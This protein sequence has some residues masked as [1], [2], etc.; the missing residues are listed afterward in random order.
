MK[1]IYKITN[2]EDIYKIGI[3]KITSKINNKVYIGSA[4]A[5]HKLKSR[6]GFYR[7]WEEHYRRLRDN[8]HRNRHLQYSWNKYGKDNFIFEILEICNKNDIITKEIYYIDKYDCTNH[9]FGYNMIKNSLVNYNKPNNETKALL[10]KLFKNIPRSADVVKK[11]SN[12]VQQLDSNRK[13]IR[14]YSSMSEASR[15]TGIMRQDIGQ[16]CIGKKIK[17]AGGYFWKKVKDIV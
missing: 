5:Q 10:S 7:R 13:L 2:I 17:K 6:C 14:E 12:P 1:D 9:K 11:Y 4:S 15:I 16:A 3:Y 8:T